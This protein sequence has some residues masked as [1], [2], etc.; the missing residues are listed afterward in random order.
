MH[1]YTDQTYMYPT[2]QN[3]LPTDHERLST[4]A[5][6][7]DEIKSKSKSR[8]RRS[9]KVTATSRREQLEEIMMRKRT[10]TR[11][12]GAQRGLEPRPRPSPGLL[13]STTAQAR[14]RKSAIVQLRLG[15]RPQPE[16]AA[17]PTGSP[18][19]FH[20]AKSRHLNH[21][22]LRIAAQKKNASDV[23]Q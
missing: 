14:A 19:R 2:V 16:D 13:P 3:T 17:T 7:R 4:R 21:L 12:L 18:A 1:K 10:R 22:R 8:S 20:R 5:S 11:S 23:N 6:G 9:S 15:Y